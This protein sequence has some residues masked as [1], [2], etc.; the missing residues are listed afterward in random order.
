VLFLG[1]AFLYETLVAFWQ[2]AQASVWK[3]QATLAVLSVSFVGASLLAFRY[4]NLL[5]RVFYTLAAIWLG[6]FSF[7]FYAACLCWGVWG[8]AA[9]L[10]FHPQRQSVAVV[11]FGAAL[12][13]SAYGILNAA[14]PRVKR[15]TV[16]LP[17]LP[18][19]WRG[20]AAALVS[21][22]HLGHVRNR[23]F[24]RRIVAKLGR[25]APD[26][27]F[28]AGDLYDGTAA[29]VRRLAEPLTKL[30]PPFGT[31]FV[32][33]NHE[34]FSDHTKYFEA[35]RSAGVRVLN[36]EKI[37]LDGLQLLGVHYRDGAR[38]ER[39]RP[40]LRRAAVVRERASVLLNHGPHLLEIAEEEGISLQLSGH[41]HGGQFFPY[42]RIVSRIYGTYAYGL[43]RFGSMLVC[44]SCGAGTW[45]PPLRVGTSPEIVLI[46]FE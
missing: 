9:L 21:D 34:E 26:I 41:T 16:K 28:I 30:S 6:T 13:V 15:V 17:N 23:G 25:L 43:Q 1:H 3:L 14:L 44:T 7:C 10:G 2:P 20:R 35:A 33:G 40:I 11:I 12:V 45:G 38:P 24:I 18:E 19:S 27:V 37:V 31:Y 46:R 5:V 39:L 4:A 36:N 32:A 22:T 29:D 8:A 42:T